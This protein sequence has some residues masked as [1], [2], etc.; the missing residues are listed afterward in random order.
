[1]CGIARLSTRSIA[2]TMIFMITAMI[3]VAIMRHGVG[4]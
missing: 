4:G 2:A 1:V 3:V